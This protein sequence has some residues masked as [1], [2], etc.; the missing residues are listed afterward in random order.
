MKN[1]FTYLF[2][3]LLSINLSCYK[4]QTCTIDYSYT[5]PGVY[6]DSLSTGYVSTPYSEDVTFV[7]I[8]DTM[9]A[10]ITNF[11]ILNIALPVG[12]SWQCDN[13][14]G[15]CNYN[16]QSNIY[17][18]I[19][20]YGTPL[21]AGNYDV[22][23]T[24]LCDVVASGQ[25]INDIPISFFIYMEV[26]QNNPGS[27]NSGFTMSSSS[28]CSPVEIDFTNNNPGL[29]AYTWDFGNGN[30]SAAENPSTQQYTTTGEYLI[31]YQAYNSLD[32]VDV[33]TLTSVT[34]EDVTEDWT[35]APWGWEL[36]N[37]NKPDP[38]FILYENGNLIYQSTFEYNDNGP[39]TWTMNINL[40]P[41]SIYEI[42]V[43]DADESAA[44]VNT[45]EFTYGTDDF[46]GAHNLNFNGCNNCSAGNF[47]DI[48]YTIDYLQILPSPTIQSLDTLVVNANPGQPNINFN[49]NDFVLSTDST[50]YGLQWYA[51]D[52]II[53][54]QTQS[55]DTISV[56]GYYHVVAF[57][58]FGC[59]TSSDT[60]YA[61]FCD[62]TF[63][64]P[65]IDINSALE[66]YTSAPPGWNIQWYN[67]GT[68]IP[69]ADSANFLPSNTGNFTVSITNP[70]SCM[71][72]SLVYIYTVGINN[73]DE[74]MWSLYPN[75]TS[76][77]ITLNWSA[78]LK[79][80]T[81]RVMN[82]LGE[83]IKTSSKVNG[84]STTIDL[85]ALPGGTYLVK[86]A[87]D[88]GILTKNVL[89]KN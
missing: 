63:P 25:T 76:N 6:P 40:D 21:L 14:A 82:V 79:V 86:L 57:N 2:L 58:N 20:I 5:Q 3:T 88:K 61:V 75:P 77:L 8:L 36:F 26:S 78:N 45:A 34:V 64:N 30:T 32:T 59:A 83:V 70:D 49:A 44:Q 33:Y 29:I 65:L 67:N 74:N 28:G 18:C 19:N 12:L 31:N 48:S 89:L 54:G 35:G 17:G 60:I 47:S 56:S 41:N 62:S 39:I 1:I 84:H 43:M 69:G 9:G 87:T 52:T 16:P 4:A 51:N 68:A 23:V 71:Y 46:I 81:I 53:P 73:L 27:G 37:G 15:G 7:M 55:T 24:I 85:S 80:N 72:T 22:E 50:Q 66:L 11:Q 13:A 10:T 38:Y 42:S